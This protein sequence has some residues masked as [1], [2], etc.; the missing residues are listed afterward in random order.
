MVTGVELGGS[1][2]VEL[3]CIEVGGFVYL[4]V[5]LGVTVIGVCL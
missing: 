1:E 4:E 2:V 3:D 5:Q